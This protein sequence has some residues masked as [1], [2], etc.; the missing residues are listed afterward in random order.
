[1]EVATLGCLDRRTRPG[2]CSSR[3]SRSRYS[4]LSDDACE[5]ANCHSETLRLLAAESSSG[6]DLMPLQEERQFKPEYAGYAR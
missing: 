6:P 1:M 4:V 2:L 3:S 5:R